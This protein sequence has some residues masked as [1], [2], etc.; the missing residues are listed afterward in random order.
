MGLLLQGGRV[1]DPAQGLDADRDVLLDAGRVAAV[2]AE[3]SPD[4]H[5]SVNARG[6]VVC[7]GF[8]D[9][10]VHFREPGEEY[11]ETIRTGAV[12]AAAGGFTTVCCMPNTD[13]AIDD[14][15]VL[16][17]IHERAESACGV[18]VL[19]NAA[20][21]KGNRGEELAEMGRLADAGAVMFSDDAFPIQHSGL[22]RRAMEYARMVGLP[23]TLHCEDKG[24][25]GAGVMNEGPTATMLGLKGIPAASEEIMVARNI[26]LARLT[27]VHLHIC[28]VST[29][30]ATELVRRAKA[31]GIA[32]SA[33]A[34]PHH[35]TLTDDCCR[36][37]NT[38]AKVNPPLRTQRDVEAVTRG[39][40]DG[41]LD[42]IATDHAPHAAHE[43]E[44]EFD[45]A[46][47][48]LVGLETAVPLVLDHLVRPGALTLSQA[49]E[50]LATNPARVLLA[51]ETA[52]RRLGPDLG[53]LRVGAPA[54]VTLLDLEAEVH[55][56]AEKLLSKSKNTPYDGWRLTGKP[57]M[58][59]VSGEIV[60]RG[61]IVR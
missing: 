39:L 18:R 23:V 46:P 58:T 11:K 9:L 44:Q 1:V 34:C 3:L 17:L 13:P 7:P 59:I 45:R 55:V 14:P 10:H 27:G 32:L 25:S 41:T 51:G 57:V 61:G 60:M 42:C 28:H 2:A 56:E 54:D 33:E 47:F 30:G 6:L 37:Y 38:N 49:I 12:S 22:M 21:T 4:G 40:T 5:E 19:V 43:K 35:F 50:R 16:E 15:S 48:G 31:E 8:I 26:E 20:M 29:A 52:R 53:T 36:G 24:L